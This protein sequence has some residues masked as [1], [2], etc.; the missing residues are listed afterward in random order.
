MEP[1]LRSKVKQVMEKDQ[2]QLLY[3]NA[4]NPFIH[5]SFHLPFNKIYTC[6]CSKLIGYITRPSTGSSCFR[7]TYIPM[8][9]GDI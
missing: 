6:L 4:I 5:P 9:G 8:G 2:I 3:S 7:R 1:K